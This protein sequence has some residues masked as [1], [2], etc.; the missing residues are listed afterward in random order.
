MTYHHQ[1]ASTFLWVP[2]IHDSV[3]FNTRSGKVMEMQKHADL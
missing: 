2:P 1:P 3:C